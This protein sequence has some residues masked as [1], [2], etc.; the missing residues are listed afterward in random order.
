MIAVMGTWF[1]FISNIRNPLLEMCYK[2]TTLFLTIILQQPHPWDIRFTVTPIL[3]FSLIPTIQH[4]FLQRS[5]PA[6]HGKYFFYGTIFTLLAMPFFILGM[7][8]KHDPYRVYHG[9]WHCCGGFASLFYWL[10]MKRSIMIYSR[11]G[12]KHI[13]KQLL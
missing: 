12:D 13:R 3:L 11:N 8:D 4:C 9:L 10:M 2:Y 1:V 5:L 7:D 6:V